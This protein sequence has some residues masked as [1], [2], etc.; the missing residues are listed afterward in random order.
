M[1]C[2]GDGELLFFLHNK[3]KHCFQIEQCLNGTLALFENL[4]NANDSQKLYVYASLK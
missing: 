1:V 3:N 2:S 4:H